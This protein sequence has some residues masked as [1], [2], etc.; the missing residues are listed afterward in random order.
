MPIPPTIW[1]TLHASKGGKGYK[2]DKVETN[3][4]Y[5]G[6]GFSFVLINNY[7]ISKFTPAQPKGAQATMEKVKAILTSLLL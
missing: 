5:L 7:Q 4:T 2:N 6:L 1:E 3:K